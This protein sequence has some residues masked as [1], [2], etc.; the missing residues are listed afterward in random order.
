MYARFFIH[1]I[2][3]N[4]QDNFLKNMKKMI[5]NKGLI[6]FEFRTFK[7]PL[8]NKGIKISKYE[9]YDDHYRRFIDPHE[10]KNKLRKMNYKIIY[11]KTSNKYAVYQNQRPHI[12]RMILKKIN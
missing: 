6:F 10:F 4:Q 3:E 1:A 12:C 2:N 5:N 7:D 9:R 11:F 8:I